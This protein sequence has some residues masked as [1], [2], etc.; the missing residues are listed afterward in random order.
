MRLYFLLLTFTLLVSGC[1]RSTVDPS[2]PISDEQ[3]PEP[4]LVEVQTLTDSLYISSQTIYTR[5]ANTDVRISCRF[6]LAYSSLR[7]SQIREV[8]FCLSSTDSVLSVKNPQHLRLK[9]TLDT[10]QYLFTADIQNLSPGQRYY[11]EPYIIFKNGR[12]YYGRYL[13]TPRL[14]TPSWLP[15]PPMNAIT[16]F[17]APQTDKSAYKP[18]TVLN[19]ATVPFTSLLYDDYFFTC[20]DKLYVLG[21]E[22]SLF[23]YDAD[24][25]KWVARQRLTI[26][27]S[28]RFNGSPAIVFSVN[29]K[30]YVLY[31]DILSHS[32]TFQW[33]YNPELDQWTKISTPD[34]PDIT[35]YK[36]AYQQNN[37]VFLS[38]IYRKQIL[39]FDAQQKS[40]QAVN[41]TNVID[42]LT[43]YRP[44]VNVAS[45]P[46]AYFSRYDETGN[47]EL[48]ASRYDPLT[49]RFGEDKLVS[50]RKSDLQPSF[51]VASTDDLLLG[52]GTSTRLIP[53]S[54]IITHSMV[55]NDDLIRYATTSGQVTARY[56][57]SA[58]TNSAYDSPF[59]SYRALFV[60][61]RIYAIDQ[62]N[63]HM[64][65]LRF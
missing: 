21:R 24:Q 3:L 36:Y 52:L 6:G 51:A 30:G 50:D 26:E 18:L 54:R 12:V 29:N 58:L 20:N 22:G 47:G 49:D 44:I 33:E 37:Q 62:S 35:A 4:P 60:G 57:L 13:P 55:I 48:Y 53:E 19:R 61:G 38:D 64:R 41:S 7:A 1:H 10:S 65:E 23:Q 17:T 2:Q 46:Y 15:R 42:Y 9:A 45:T 40:F 32:A 34:T 14:Q 39:R 56:D 11:L 16:R 59:S 28:D 63:S 8:G 5:T 27:P 31:K 43:N 25:D